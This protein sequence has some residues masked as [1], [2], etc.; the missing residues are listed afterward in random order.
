MNEVQSFLAKRAE[1]S[2]KL[3]EEIEATEQKLVELK[4]TAA[5]LYSENTS[6]PTKDKKSKKVKAKPLSSAADSSV[7]PPQAEEAA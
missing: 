4:K 5:M 7:E 2:Q 3:A 1:L 6:S